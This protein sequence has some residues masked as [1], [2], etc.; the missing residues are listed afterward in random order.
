MTAA[1]AHGCRFLL[2]AVAG[3]TKRSFLVNGLDVLGE[4]PAG[5][6]ALFMGLRRPIQI[7]R[8]TPWKV[9]AKGKP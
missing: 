6:S 8:G 1:P 9:K 4:P 5:M 3:E 2:V 7:F